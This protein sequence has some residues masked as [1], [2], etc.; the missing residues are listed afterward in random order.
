MKSDV[1]CCVVLCSNK[2]KWMISFNWKW[3][4]IKTRNDWKCF[5]LQ[6][7]LFESNVLWMNQRMEAIFARATINE[8]FMHCLNSNR[9][10]LLVF[11]LS[12]ME[13]TREWTYDITFERKLVC[14]KALTIKW[15]LSFPFSRIEERFDC[16]FQFS[17]LFSIT[18]RSQLLF[19]IYYYSSLLFTNKTQ[20]LQKHIQNKVTFQYSLI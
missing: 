4:I 20:T 16:Y 8:W 15:E 13:N 5:A 18:K 10:L 19:F 12:K 9:N 3:D 6:C 7:L 11:A 17:T 1:L 2:V 14:F